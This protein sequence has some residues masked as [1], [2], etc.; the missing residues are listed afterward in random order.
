M[1]DEKLSAAKLAQILGLW[2]DTNLL[3]WNKKY[4]YICAL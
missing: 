4:S 2:N 1:H 3:V